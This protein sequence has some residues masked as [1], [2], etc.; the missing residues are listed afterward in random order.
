MKKIV[1]YL[2]LIFVLCNSQSSFSNVYQCVDAAGQITF[3][4][5]PCPKESEAQLLNIESAQTSASSESTKIKEGLDIEPDCVRLARPV[6]NALARESGGQLSPDEMNA[7]STARQQ[8][9]Q[10]CKMRLSI[11]SLSIDCASKKNQLTQSLT[12]SKDLIEAIER[13]RQQGLYEQSCNEQ[14]IHLDIEK[15]LRLIDDKP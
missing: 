11:T 7:L 10:Q 14:A 2:G 4:D 13:K 9:E 15:H 12:K 5:R 6:W 1:T 3:T 8:L